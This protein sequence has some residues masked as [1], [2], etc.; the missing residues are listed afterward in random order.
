[1]RRSPPV[2]ARGENPPDAIRLLLLPLENDSSDTSLDW[3]TPVSSGI[4]EYDLNTV[5]NWNVFRG[6][7]VRAIAD[8]RANRVL[9]G[10]FSLDG[11]N[12]LSLHAT[13]EAPLERKTLKLIVREGPAGA[14]I[15]P[16]LDS[17]AKE[18]NPAARPFSSQ[19]PAALR[20]YGEALQNPD[21]AARIRLLDTAATQD[22]KLSAAGIALAEI[23]L[24][25][26]DRPHAAEVASRG[27]SNASDPTDRARLEY[28]AATA[29][30]NFP[31]REKALQTLAKLSPSANTFDLLGQVH[32][33][34]RQFKDA[35]HDYEAVVPP[36]AAQSRPLQLHRLP[37]RLPAR[38][39]QRR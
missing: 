4:L 17:L 28:L 18:L 8:S 10:Y 30:E 24:S 29:R 32:T 34:A 3:Q 31:A 2:P 11:P 13:L 25:Q 37:L 7:S 26:G 5:P 19:D 16:L 36:G 27:A 12:R 9:Q 22:P 20:S 6:D 23:L 35:I 1:M 38:S 21:P 15:Q 33:S 14:G 39:R